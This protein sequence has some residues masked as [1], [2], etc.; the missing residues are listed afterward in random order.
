MHFQVVDQRFN[1][2]GRPGGVAKGKVLVEPTVQPNK[3]VEMATKLATSLINLQAS[4][5]LVEAF[6][7][8]QAAQ[9]MLRG[10]VF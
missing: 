2:P 4:P 1:A 3:R 8:T 6:M 7:K 9:D 10:R 5:A